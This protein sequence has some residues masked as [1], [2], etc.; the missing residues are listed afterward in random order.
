VITVVGSANMDLTARVARFPSPGQTV[1]ATS[2]T[3]TPG[4]KGANQAVAAA[5]A[6]SPTAFVGRVGEDSY[7]LELVGSLQ[8]AGVSTDHAIRDA[9]HPTGLA[10]IHVDDA[11]ENTIV[12][13]RGANAYL[14]PLDVDRARSLMARSRLVLL[15]LET[16]EETV[17]YAAQ[18]GREAGATVIL[19][20]SPARELDPSVL[21]SVDVL[22]L[23]E[24]EVAV[25]SGM[26]AP[27][28]PASAGRLLLNAGT[29]AVIVTLGARGAVLVTPGQEVQVPTFPVRPVDSTGAG[30]AFVGNLAHALASGQDLPAAARFAAAAATL[31][32]QVVG[33]QP[34][35]P[36]AS[37]TQAL[38]KGEMPA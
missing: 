27:L 19:N 16:P 14:A 36:T 30:D 22:V 34:A 38:L 25:L 3:R 18:M 21:R 31:S 8:H 33:A 28:E 24:E 6:G 11:G 2:F 5:R 32:V 37:Q 17:A 26:G 1:L 9:Q 10:L 13:I 35:M 29:G 12:V 23:N 15:Q 4:G 20:P 7:G